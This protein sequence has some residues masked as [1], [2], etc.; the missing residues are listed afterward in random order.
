M[1]VSLYLVM[2]F[3]MF[4]SF[5]GV[6]WWVLILPMSFCVQLESRQPKVYVKKKNQY[7]PFC[8][9]KQGKKRYKLCPG[10]VTAYWWG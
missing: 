4:V 1:F 5:Q 9:P 6:E 3:P 2:I 10:E 8:C 7:Q